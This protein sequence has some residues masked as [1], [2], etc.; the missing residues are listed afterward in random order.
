MTFYFWGDTTEYNTN[1]V[2]TQQV[3]RK[4]NVYIRNIDAQGDYEN[5]LL[6]RIATH[7][8]PDLFYAP[9]WWLPDLA[10]K[11]LL[12]NLDPY[13]AKD[14]SFNRR[15]YVPQALRGLTYHGHLYSLP[16]GFSPTVLYYNK[17][18]FDQM[19]VAYPTANWTL[20]DLL[21]AAQKLTNKQHW[22]LMLHN[23]PGAGDK[24]NFFY[25]LWSFGTDYVN[26]AGTMCTLTDNKARQA[27][28]WVVDLTY[29][30]HVQPTAAEIAKNGDWSGA[31]FDSGKVAMVLGAQ[32]WFYLY[33]PLIGTGA[34]PFRWD[35]Q[36]PPL[37]L[38]GIH[39]YSYPGYAGLG[40]WTGTRNRNLAYQVGKAISESAGQI[41]IAKAGIDLPA[42]EPALHSSAPFIA[43]DPQADT[44]ALQAIPYTRIPHYVVN[45]RDVQLTLDHDLLNVW[46]NKDTVAHA[47]Q[48]ACSDINPLLK[49]R[50]G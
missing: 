35:V 49:K 1:V 30:Y 14:R 47:T 38:D 33:A 23:G 4:L 36:L 9:D 5:G 32:R 10:A 12:L 27:F 11:G 22:G 3:A 41:A 46:A 20:A 7:N 24:P 8:G 17:D 43:P 26:G 28:Q 16:R 21:R 6:T 2:A 31:L 44:I 34:P 42:F 19:H 37:A 29:K 18:I 48:K 13:I 39:R 15:N 50:S 40:I 25:F 45:M